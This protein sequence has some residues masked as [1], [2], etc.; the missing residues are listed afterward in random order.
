MSCTVVHCDRAAGGSE[1]NC[2]STEVSDGSGIDQ[3]VC[4]VV[5]QTGTCQG[6]FENA[7]DFKVSYLSLCCGKVG[8][9]IGKVVSKALGIVGLSSNWKVAVYVV[10]VY[11]AAHVYSLL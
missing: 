6:A 3:V 1:L 2:H 4:H 11:A 9:D 5:V 7:L 8:F 10:G